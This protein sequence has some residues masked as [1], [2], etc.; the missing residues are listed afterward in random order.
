MRFLALTSFIPVVF[1]SAYENPDILTTGT[2][3]PIDNEWTSTLTEAT[4]SEPSNAWTTEATTSEPS[5]APITETPSSLPTFYRRRV[6]IQ[7]D[8]P[9]TA[10]TPRRVESVWPTNPPT[11]VTTTTL[12]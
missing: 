8:Y 6:F 9:V 1:V 3:Y 4:T 5:T 2:P 11:I 7:S 12:V 10:D